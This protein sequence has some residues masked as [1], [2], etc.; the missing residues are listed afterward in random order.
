MHHLFRL[1]EKLY[2]AYY[3]YSYSY[4]RTVS[5]NK[6]MKENSKYKLQ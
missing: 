1:S 6:I 4:Q 3:G 2:N 5:N